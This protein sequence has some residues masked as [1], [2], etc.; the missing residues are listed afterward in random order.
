MVDTITHHSSL[1]SLSFFDCGDNG[2]T[3][4]HHH[5][6]SH[7]F[8]FLCAGYAPRSCKQLKDDFN[9]HTDGLYTLTTADGAV[10][11]TFCDMTT[12]GGG[13]TLVASVH[14]NNLYGKCT[15]GD[16]WSSQQGDDPRWPEGDGNWANR[17][18]FG[19][20]EGATSDDFKNPGYYDIRAED[21]S[22]WHPKL[23]CLMKKNN[24]TFVFFFFFFF[25]FN[26]KRFQV[27]FNVG[28]CITNNGPSIPIIYDHGSRATT[29]HFYGPSAR[30]QFD[31]GYITFRAINTE[32]A[33]TA[34]CSGTKPKGCHIE[35]F[36]I[37]GGGHFPEARPRQCGDFTSF[38]WNGYGSHN[39]WSAS[40]QITEAAVFLFYR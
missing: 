25:F 4:T 37:G 24:P 36:C 22:V 28:G 35:H 26:V 13:W 34:I 1:P 20:A 18:V 15:V 21:V 7:Q 6:T 39:S 17:N 10:Y 33:A 14:E 5:I 30:T 27:K 32:R 8:H 11:Q 9:V 2:N 16:R 29:T 12:A 40:R 23:L 3:G 19:T 38:D 31:A